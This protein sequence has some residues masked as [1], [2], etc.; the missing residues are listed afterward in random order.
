MQVSYMTTESDTPSQRNI[1]QALDFFEFA[2][3]I[4]SGD[5]DALPIA[6][7]LCD[8]STSSLMYVPTDVGAI[9]MISSDDDHSYHA[10]FPHVSNEDDP[11]ICA[12]IYM[13][14]YSEVPLEMVIP[15]ETGQRIVEAYFA[16][17]FPQAFEAGSWES[18][19]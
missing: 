12:F 9:M 8:G 14:A 13:G 10:A 2:K 7:E 11:A 15:E 1:N 6:L 18:D 17:G 3:S 5:P 4:N 16:G 19:W